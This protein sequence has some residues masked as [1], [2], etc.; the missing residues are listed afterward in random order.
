MTNKKPERWNE[1]IIQA[2]FATLTKKQVF[3]YYT[4]PLVKNEILKA[5][6]NR[7]VVVRQS[8]A[9]GKDVLRRKDPFG[10]LI[11]FETPKAF[12]QLTEKRLSEVHPTF[13]RH[14]NFMLVD[15][16]PQKNVPWKKTKAIAETVAKT[17]QMHP[18][19]KKV[20]VQFSGGRGFYVR[21]IMN[22]AIKVD[23]ARALTQKVLG[24][25][26]KRPD[27]TFGVTRSPSQIR[28]DTTP[29][30]FRGSVRA[31]MSLNASTGL[32]SAPVTLAKLPKVEKSDFT[33][34]KIVKKAEEL[35]FPTG[36]G[37][38]VATGK[39]NTT[40]RMANELGKYEAGK[41]YDSPQGKIY[42]DSIVRA[43]VK[44]LRDH[45]IPR[46]S[47]KRIAREGGKPGTPVNVVRFY[48][49]SPVRLPKSEPTPAE[50]EKNR[51]MRRILANLHASGKIA[52]QMDVIDQEATEGDQGVRYRREG[53]AETNLPE[54][55]SGDRM[56]TIK[57]RA[58]RLAVRLKTAEREFAP[59]IPKARVTHPIPD[60][61]NKAWTLAIQQHDAF[62][63]GPHWDVRL[64]D[65]A[66][67]RAH[68]FA[69]PKMKF[70]EKGETI[71]GIQQPTHKRRYALKFEGDI[72][73]GVYGGGSV[74][75]HLKEPVD[76]I[77]ANANRIV[78][79][80]PD[81]NKFVMFR[82]DDKKWG[83]R[84]LT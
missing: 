79:Q 50:K 82:M 25:I 37:P 62:K 5:V 26:A 65:P 33:I 14:V 43:K 69:V 31:P 17:M 11:K 75:M 76:I 27:V 51:L 66:T 73:K 34:Q 74:K 53:E 3:K 39:K 6:G 49:P 22:K 54:H 47:L 48:L 4:N 77:K 32:V 20:E 58:E 36:Y 83:I 21:G 61:Q 35:R 63:A 7:E 42:V 24:G 8:F 28:L 18:D 16:D 55:P 10:Q 41:T 30:K 70:P 2:P 80:R 67:A 29:L 64:V 60:I 40:I 72:P 13:G 68:S 23:Q 12:K 52:A 56:H 38:A 78:M 9:P 84:K 57:D 1:P 45:G 46:S 59:G 15:I 44:E 81:G 19:V 71:L